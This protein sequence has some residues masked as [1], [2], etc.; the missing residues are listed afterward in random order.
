MPS[1]WR[2][3][4]SL[5]CDNCRFLVAFEQQCP[6]PK[7]FQVCGEL[8]ENVFLFTLVLANMHKRDSRLVIVH[9]KD[10]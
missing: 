3:N 10:G 6:I 9:S 5:Q 4:G 7:P 1:N 2:A 8:W